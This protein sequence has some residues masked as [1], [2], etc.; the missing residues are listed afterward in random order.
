M[1][2]RENGATAFHFAALE[3]RQHRS[4]MQVITDVVWRIVMLMTMCYKP[5]L[6]GAA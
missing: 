1:G 3:G 2:A 5:R 6:V 4:V